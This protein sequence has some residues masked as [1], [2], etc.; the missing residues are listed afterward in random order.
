[1]SDSLRPQIHSITS[2]SCETSFLV[3]RKTR[4]ISTNQ[5]PLHLKELENEEQTKPKASRSKEIIKTRTETKEIE[6][7]KQQIN[8][9]EKK[10]QK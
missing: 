8:V 6:T 9:T 2:L 10:A 3:S 7:K 1:M 5:Q 4:K